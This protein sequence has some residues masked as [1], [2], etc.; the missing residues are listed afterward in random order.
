VYVGLLLWEKSINQKF[1]VWPDNEIRINPFKFCSTSIAEQKLS[2][3][4]WVEPCSFVFG[5]SK[6]LNI[7]NSPF[8]DCELKSVSVETEINLPR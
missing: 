4:C 2:E 7:E 1:V 6:T 5:L 3:Y 8:F